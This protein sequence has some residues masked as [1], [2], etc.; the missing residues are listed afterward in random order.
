MEFM[1]KQD[2]QFIEFVTEQNDKYQLWKLGKIFS[3]RYQSAFIGN[4][5]HKSRSQ[6]TPVLHVITAY[7]LNLS[8]LN[9]QISFHKNDDFWLINIYD[10]DPD[11]VCLELTKAVIDSNVFLYTEDDDGIIIHEC[12]H[13][14]VSLFIYCHYS[15]LS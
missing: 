3:M 15:R 6:L 8:A 13:I 9:Q 10:E 4:I 12:W 11:E 5:V 7:N 2:V 1:K 14:Q